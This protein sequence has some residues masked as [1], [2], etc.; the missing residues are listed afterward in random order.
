MLKQPNVSEIGKTTVFSLPE[1][2]YNLIEFLYAS[3]THTL[4]RGCDWT[5]LMIFKM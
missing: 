5:V 3:N 2:C 4:T 1:N